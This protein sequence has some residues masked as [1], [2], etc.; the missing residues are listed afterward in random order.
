MCDDKGGE[1]GQIAQ[2]ISELISKNVWG[3][4]KSEVLLI[5]QWGISLCR[6]L[7]TEQSIYQG[8]KCFMTFEFVC[9]FT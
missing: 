3:L 6:Q 5:P 2:V 1:T 8:M 4:V 9:L 7:W